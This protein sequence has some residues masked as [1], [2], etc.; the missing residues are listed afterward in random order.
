MLRMKTNFVG[1]HMHTHARAHTHT[2][3]EFLTEYKRKFNLIYE[4]TSSPQT[5]A[6]W[7]LN[8]FL[9]LLIFLPSVSL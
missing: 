3:T 8:F 2:H 7:I 5:A 1:I 6:Y 9:I 4:G